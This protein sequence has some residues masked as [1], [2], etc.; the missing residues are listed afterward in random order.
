MRVGEGKCQFEY[1][2]EKRGWQQCKE[3]ARHIHHIEPEAWTLDRG[4]DPEQ[5]TALPLC[6]RHHIRNT[7]DEEHTRGFAFH[8]DTGEAYKHYGEWKQ[9]QQHMNAIT[10][11]RLIN[12]STSPFGDMSKEHHRRSKENDRYWAGTDE[13]DRYYEDKMRNKAVI[14]QAETGDK[15]PKTKEHSKT[16]RSKN[17]KWYDGLFD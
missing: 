8:P 12:Y 14:Y 9:Q 11:K 5:N 10:G 17:K 16:D 1:Y 4:G 2:S 15:K 13:I 6:P 7:S 3:P